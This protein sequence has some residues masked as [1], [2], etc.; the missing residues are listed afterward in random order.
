MSLYSNSVV[1]TSTPTTY[2][3]SGISPN[4]SQY[5]WTKT[6]IGYYNQIVE[7]VTE[8]RAAATYVS[9]FSDA[10]TG[11]NEKLNQIQNWYNAINSAS[12]DFNTKYADFTTKY[13]NFS[14]QYS[15]FQSSYTTFTSK[16]NEFNVDMEDFEIKYSDA[17]EMYV[18]VLEKHEDVVKIAQELL[19][20]MAYRGIW[21]PTTN[22]WPTYAGTITNSVWDVILPTGTAEHA[23]GGYTWR[24]GDRLIYTKT[25]SKWLQQASG[26]AVWSVNGKTGAV[27][28]THS[29]VNA[30]PLSGGELTGGLRGTTATMTGV[31]TGSSFVESGRVQSTVDGAVARKD[32]VDD[33]IVATKA[34]TTALVPR[35]EALEEGVSEELPFPDVWIPFSDNLRMLSGYGDDIKVGN[36]TVA[37]QA[38]F[39]RASTATYIDKSGTLRTA[40]VNEPRFEKE[41][42][43]IEGQSTNLVTNGDD[44]S[45]WPITN[46]TRE[47]VEDS[48]LLTS[49]NES[50]PR[51]LIVNSAGYPAA[52]GGAYTASV[53]VK[54]GNT[55]SCHLTFDMK[56]SKLTYRLVMNLAEL[57]VT[58]SYTSPGMTANCEYNLKKLSDGFVRVCMTLKNLPEGEIGSFFVG[59]C[60]DGGKPDVAGVGYSVHVKKGQIEALP[61]ATSYIPTNGAAATRAADICSIPMV[62]NSNIN[63]KDV[64]IGVNWDVHGYADNSYQ[65]LFQIGGNSPNNDNVR[66]FVRPGNVQMHL[67]G[68]NPQSV[69][70][71]GSTGVTSGM[72]AVKISG[73]EITAFHNSNNTQKVTVK[74][75]VVTNTQSTIGIGGDG[76]NSYYRMLFGHIRNLRI[77]HRALTNAQLKSIR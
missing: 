38:S 45:K 35:I 32:Y 48:A 31:V 61:F 51:A 3:L 73:D 6:E 5:G 21:D 50:Y 25:D 67:V 18:D 55:D 68:A 26:S 1:D 77:W 14:S 22:K 30:L 60:V 53:F 27:T 36:Y 11:L 15:N 4:V 52:A 49:T 54:P 58:N 33:Q 59:P 41:G 28:L 62:G 7:Y 20:D 65:R 13:T 16:I 9:Q 43:L 37:T 17:A 71:T 47:M 76:T 24:D 72:Y 57:K 8:V 74:D 75:W 23:H 40:A 56:E 66:A 34:E 69:V 10:L 39:S 12:R 19:Q 46:V 44:A 64:S 63:T 42:L 2:S 70:S 29:D